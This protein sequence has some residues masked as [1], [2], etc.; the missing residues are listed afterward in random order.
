[1]VSEKLIKIMK[2]AITA[3]MLLEDISNLKGIL[4]NIE[5][6]GNNTRNHELSSLSYKVYLEL[7]LFEKG[8]ERANE[9][10]K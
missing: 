8:M 4:K 5:D 9:E 3:E 7:H 10:E 1:M 2:Q 6:I